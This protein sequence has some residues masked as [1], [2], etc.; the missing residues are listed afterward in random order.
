MKCIYTL[1]QPVNHNANKQQH[2]SS[3]YSFKYTLNSI[4]PPHLTSREKDSHPLLCS[5]YAPLGETETMYKRVTM[6]APLIDDGR[7]GESESDL[8]VAQNRNWCSF[9]PSKS[10]EQSKVF[11]LV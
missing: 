11:Y 4:P 7:R 3:G 6:A 9:I 2:L 1:F 10:S 5:E 8:N